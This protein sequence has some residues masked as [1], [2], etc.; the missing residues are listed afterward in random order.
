M[1]PIFVAILAVEGWTGF[2]TRGS[3]GEIGPYQITRG[4][5]QDSGMPGKHEDCEDDA[6]SRQVMLRYWHRYCPMALERQDFR[7]LAAVHH[8]GPKG[9]KLKTF[10][11]DYVQRVM[12]IV[13]GKLRERRKV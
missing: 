2:G 9:A 12:A 1:M 13:D 5:W 6:Y 10:A 8:W 7:T 3:A 4:Y 11:D